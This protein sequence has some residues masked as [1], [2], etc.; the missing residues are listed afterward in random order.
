MSSYANEVKRV[1]NV[2]SNK[3][4]WLRG[5]VDLAIS[6][7]TNRVKKVHNFLKSELPMLQYLWPKDDMR[8][9]IYLLL[10]LLF[11]FLGKYF[12]VKVNT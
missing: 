4:G 5:L 10:S 9:R 11:M 8:L 12:N 1:S 6:P 7:V 3:L 2:N